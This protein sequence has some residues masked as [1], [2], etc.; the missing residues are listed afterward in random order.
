[1]RFKSLPEIAQLSIVDRW[2]QFVN[3]TPADLLYPRVPAA[4]WLRAFRQ[5]NVKIRAGLMPSADCME[6]V[7]DLVD[8]WVHGPAS[9]HGT[10]SCCNT[11]Y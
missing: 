7:S 4:T 2:S 11:V 10:C 9:K 3:Q 6:R 1:M 5:L 8:E